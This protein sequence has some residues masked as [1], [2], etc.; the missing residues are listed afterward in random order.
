MTNEQVSE[1]LRQHA[2]TLERQGGQLFRVRASRAAA[3]E[4]GRLDRPLEDVL[5]QSGRAGLEALPG[6]GQSLAYTIEGILRDG[7]LR[8]LREPEAPQRILMTLPGVG[9]RLAEQLRDRLGITTLEQLRTAA[10]AGQLARV[11][12]G[13][14]R[15]AGILAAVEQRLVREETPIVPSAEPSVAYLLAVDAEYRNGS[16]G[17]RL[18]TLSPRNF[19]SEGER[20]LGVL[21]S[22]R[23]GW[24]VRALFS[25]TAL[26]HRLEKTRD[27]VVIYFEKATDCGQRTVVTETRGDLLGLRVV[28]GREAECRLHYQAARSES[29]A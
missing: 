6:I 18:P 12:V 21:R 28:R 20:W 2:D 29:A 11:G 27:W 23:D 17:K 24:S 19:N 13:R 8:T 16:E 22:Q 14:K 1:R 7:G 26:A 5:R 3:L 10:H 15:L 25:N 4:I 9:P